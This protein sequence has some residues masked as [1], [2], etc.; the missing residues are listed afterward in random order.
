MTTGHHLLSPATVVVAEV[1]EV[2]L[3]VCKVH[4]LVG[5]V[6]CQSVRPVDL[7]AD[8]RRAVGSVHADSLYTRVLS[9]VCPEQ[10]PCTGITA[11]SN[12]LLHS[13]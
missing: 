8:D 12:S 11:R 6:Q 10:P 5:C 1:Y 13:G 3:R 4:S 2:Q 7:G 9:P